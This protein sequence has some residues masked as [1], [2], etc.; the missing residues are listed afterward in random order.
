MYQVRK[1]CKCHTEALDKLIW[2]SMLL[3]GSSLYSCSTRSFYINT[4]FTVYGEGGGKEGF[5]S[6]RVGGKT[7]TSEGK[8]NREKENHIRWLVGW[9]SW[10]NGCFTIQY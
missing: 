6:R 9:G 7:Q 3:D 2:S 4:L 1:L 10:A 8:Y 5:N